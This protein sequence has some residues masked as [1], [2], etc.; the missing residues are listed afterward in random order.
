[1]HILR[2]KKLETWRKIKVSEERKLFIER[3][4]DLSDAG[5]NL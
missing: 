3:G 4:H 1:M 2:K 5:Q